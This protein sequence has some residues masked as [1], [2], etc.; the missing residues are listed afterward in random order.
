MREWFLT[1]RTKR[2][3]LLLRDKL[4]K[5]NFQNGLQELK[6][7][8]PWFETSGTNRPATQRHIQEHLHKIHKTGNVRVT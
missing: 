6:M 3:A 5:K 2:F 8:M 7:S 1:F 4:T